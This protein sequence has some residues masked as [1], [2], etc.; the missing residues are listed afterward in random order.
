MPQS[1]VKKVIKLGI[2]VRDLEKSVKVWEEA[3]GVG[4]WK[5]VPKEACAKAFA[6]IQYK[7]KPLQMDIS[8]AVTKVDGLT[9]ELIQ[10]FTDE[11]PFG[12]FI[13]EH[14]E[15]IQHVAVEAEDGFIELLEQRGNK[16]LFSATMVAQNQQ[17]IYFDSI[18]D[19]GFTVEVFK[20]L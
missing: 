8:L 6:D 4:P 12:D 10:Q 18:K 13:K 9:I 16:A 1:M 3:Y 14:G 2:A 19:L 17:L 11:G 15:G 7:G 5:V 20:P